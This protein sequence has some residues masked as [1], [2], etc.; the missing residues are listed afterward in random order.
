MKT[1]WDDSVEKKNTEDSFE[2]PST[3]ND[4]F[5]NIKF[6]KPLDAMESVVF[7][8]FIDSKNTSVCYKGFRIKYKIEYG[9]QSNFLSICKC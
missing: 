9:Q 3:V 5:W 1:W 8:S 7:N 2:T 4:S 6:L